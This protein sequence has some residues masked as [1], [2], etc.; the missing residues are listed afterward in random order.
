[1][2]QKLLSK[3]VSSYIMYIRGVGGKRTLRAHID[4]LLRAYYSSPNSRDT[5]G[6]KGGEKIVGWRLDRVRN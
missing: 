3:T 2:K 1:M 5:T 6:A 4:H